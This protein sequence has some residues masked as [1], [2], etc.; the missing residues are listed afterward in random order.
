[1][2][3]IHV[4]AGSFEYD[5]IILPIFDRYPIEKLIHII[6]NEI[7]E[8]PKARKLTEHYV[9]KLK[10]IHIRLELVELDIYNFD[11]VFKKTCE[12][13][14]REAGGGLSDLS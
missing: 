12:K 5:R 6:P 14:K 9:N 1:M 10:K 2:K 4:T 8:Y 11:M 13:L 3:C 7:E